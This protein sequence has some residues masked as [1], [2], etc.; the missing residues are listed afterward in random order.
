MRE[1]C[2]GLA[3]GRAKMGL[4]RGRERDVSGDEGNKMHDTE[5]SFP[6]PRPFPPT[7]HDQ[8]SRGMGTREGT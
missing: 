1:T 7:C 3:R 6:K 8:G 2:E 5:G 4:E